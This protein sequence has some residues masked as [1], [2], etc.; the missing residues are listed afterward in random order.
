MEVGNRYL[1]KYPCSADSSCSGEVINSNINN[2]YKKIQRGLNGEINAP[3]G[4]EPEKNMLKY[5]QR[6]FETY[7]KE[8]FL[9]LGEENFDIISFIRTLYEMKGCII[10]KEKCRIS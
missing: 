3:E 4:F 6:K 2:N 5:F 8:R 9:D 1:Q 10:Q 7:F